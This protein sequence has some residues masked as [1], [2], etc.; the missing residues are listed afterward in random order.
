MKLVNYINTSKVRVIDGKEY[1]LS[2]FMIEFDND[3]GKPVKILFTPVNKSDYD[4]LRRV[5]IRVHI[6]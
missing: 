5:A 1:P 3:N 6:K 4:Y 2:Y